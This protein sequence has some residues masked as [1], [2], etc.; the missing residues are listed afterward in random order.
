MMN[1]SPG[2]RN[3]FKLELLIT[4]SC[5]LICQ[6]FKKRYSLFNV[7]Q[8]WDD[9]STC[10][11]NYLTNVIA[12]NKN[13]N[14]TSVQKTSV[15]Q[16]DSNEWDLTTLTALLLFIDRPKSLSTTETQEFDNED[17][18]LKRLRDIRNKLAHHATKYLAEPEFNQLWAELSRILVA[19]GDVDTELDKLKDDSVFESRTESINEDNVNEASRIN[20]LGTQA[21]KKQKFSAAITLFT[22]A[23]VLPGVSE[24]D[25]ATFYS[26]MASTRLA[27]YEQQA[28]SLNEFEVDDATDQWFRALRD[29]KHARI[30]WSIW[31][32]G[33]FRVGKVYAGLN[34][35]EKAINSFERALAL[36]PT[37]SE[38][39]KA[40]DASRHIHGRQG[41]QEHLDPRLQ[42]R[43]M[44]E[45]FNEMQQKLG[46]DPEKVRMIH[47][48]IEKID[49]AGADVVRGHKYEHGDVGVK[50]DYEQAA[51]YF[52]KAAR[53][54]NA[55]GMYNLARL[56][57]RGLGVKKDHNMALKLLE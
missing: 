35:H 48:F 25:R 37:N 45:L 24:H 32:K 49:P 50:Q 46:T 51:I 5:V 42:P 1:I 40:L 38:I 3:Y 10:G 56:T 2:V 31:W 47:G 18:L 30:L 54:G 17:K 34:E 16:G 28:S 44:D 22:K 36:S 19:F 53:Q 41:R 11:S 29:A 26:N 20:S 55:Q 27:L 7:G 8:V 4:R 43:T 9:S 52:G 57:D 23:T 21:H 12:K 15:S 13:I 33:H 39:Q 14:L 6:L